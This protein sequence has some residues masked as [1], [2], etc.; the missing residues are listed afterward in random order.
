MALRGSLQRLRYNNSF[1]SILL[2]SH[3]HG[4][5][6]GKMTGADVS[7][8]QA[9]Q[10]K[11]PVVHCEVWLVLSSRFQRFQFDPNSSSQSVARPHVRGERLCHDIWNKYWR[12]AETVLKES[13][14]SHQA[15]GCE[16][17]ANTHWSSICPSLFSV[18]SFTGQ[19]GHAQLLPESYAKGQVQKSFVS[20]FRI[21]EASVSWRVCLLQTS[22][23]HNSEMACVN[24]AQEER[25]E[26]K[27]FE[28]H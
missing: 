23:Q 25:W 11:V 8:N 26:L 12:L 13:R 5:V 2:L 14:K 15:V 28:L 6:N 21:V 16:S 19:W 9:A 3:K 10:R 7:D 24:A 18:V 17:G 22:S 4:S 27:F 1:F 20:N